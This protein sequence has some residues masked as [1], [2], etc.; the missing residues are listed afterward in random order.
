MVLVVFISALAMILI[1]ALYYRSLAFLPF[2]AG[3]LSTSV[4]NAVKVI[5]LDR[6]VVKVAAMEKT[7][8]GA[9]AGFM[10]FLRFLLT[11][12]V[13]GLVFISH[14]RVSIWG[15]VAGIFTLQIAAVATKYFPDTD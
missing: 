12:A 15:A 2:A 10:Y 9:Y 7:K 8:S 3:V 11:G 5:L 6:T 14:P 1:S 4:L 13:L